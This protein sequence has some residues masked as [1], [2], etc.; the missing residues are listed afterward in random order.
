MGNEVYKDTK[1]TFNNTTLFLLNISISLSVYLHLILATVLLVRIMV[2]SST[3]CLCRTS[4]LAGIQI[5]HHYYVCKPRKGRPVDFNL[6][7]KFQSY[8]FSQVITI[9]T[10]NCIYR[11]SG[12]NPFDLQADNNGVNG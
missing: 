1:F 5:V 10:Y 4:H 3:T 6:T 2:P 11:P 9:C 8:T 7:C 12:K